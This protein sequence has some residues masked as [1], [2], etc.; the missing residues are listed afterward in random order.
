MAGPVA[1]FGGSGCR[2]DC[3]GGGRVDR[4]AALTGLALLGKSGK[5][6]VAFV[7]EVRL[8]SASSAVGFTL[9]GAGERGA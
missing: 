7:V 3:I 1:R 2:I 5:L 6:D 9:D 4:E 8:F